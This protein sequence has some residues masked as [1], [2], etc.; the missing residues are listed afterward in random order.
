M[1]HNPHRGEVALK[2]AETEV[3]LRPEIRS[4]IAIE[5]DL[6]L[7]IVEVA[8]KI[9]KGN[10]RLGEMA[11]VVFHG[12]VKD[13]NFVITK[14]KVAE[15]IFKTGMANEELWVSVY[16]FLCNCL[17]GGSS[18]KKEPGEVEATA[19]TTAG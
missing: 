13:A 18:P 19:S 5:T 2:L 14:E 8:R 9:E 16:E 1:T 4:I 3:L 6:N 11:T 7:S 10:I 15:Q 12:M 17:M